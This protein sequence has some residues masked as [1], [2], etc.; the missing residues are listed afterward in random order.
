MKKLRAGVIGTGFIGAVHVETLRRLGNVDLVAIADILNAEKS[1]KS[2]SVPAFYEDYQEMIKQEKL[3]AVHIC[4]PNGFH[5]EQATFA[6]ENG[7]SVFCEKPLTTTVEE[8][9]ILRDLANEK[10][11]PCGINF[12]FRFNPM[13]RQIKEMMER[14]EVGRVYSVHGSYL[15]DWLYYDTDY[16]WRLEPEV[17][18]N[19][20]AFADIGSHWID[21]VENTTGLRV[22]EVMADFATFH[23]TRKKPLKPIETYSGMALKP[24]D[25][26]PILIG[27]EDYSAVLF[28]FDNGAHGS[29]VISQMFAGRKNATT[30]SIGGSKCALHWDSEAANE[31]WIGRRET[32]NQ[33]AVKDPSILYPSTQSIIS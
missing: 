2:L 19:S 20:R 9:K 1:S 31:L 25:Y 32:F 4:T 24:E 10:G 18:G 21:M 8:A 29:C 28:H 12:M 7:V 3:D 33:T 27:T 13:V 17:T 16:N 6:I 15:Q 30:L 23:E 26:Q 22:R 11:V 14:G 5:F